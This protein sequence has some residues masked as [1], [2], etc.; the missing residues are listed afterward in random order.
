[1]NKNTAIGLLIAVIVLGGGYLLIKHN[2]TAD[3][4]TQTPVTSTTGGDQT[5]PPTP[6]GTISP[7]PGLPTV[8]TS[9]N[10]GP[11]SVGAIVTGQVNPNGASTTYWFDYGTTTALGT[12]TPAQG[13]GS[14][15]SPIAAPAY[16]TGLRATTQYY[17]RLSAQN[18]FGT[19]NGATYTLMTNN[20]PPPQG[21]APTT[22]T[23]AA[24]NISRTTANLNGQVKPNNSSTTYWFEYGRDSG[25]GSVTSPQSAGSGTAFV[26]ASVSVSNLQPLTQYFF[27]LNAQNQYGTINGAILSFTT[28]GPSS[29]GTPTVE[30]SSPSNVSRTDAFLNGS[31]NPNG[32]ATTYWFEY[33]E[34]SLL[35][36]LI[37]SG[38]PEKTIAAG[39]TNVKVQAK[40]TG[41]QNNTTYYYHLVGRNADGT[42]FGNVVS[43]RTKS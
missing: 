1:M 31:I 22:T 10:T 3:D 34:D 2:Q 39:T 25:L 23:T 12:Q 7:T 5:P 13:V 17:F 8:S 26:S 40:I 38:T 33:S 24:S 27:R 30:T 35:G 9:S 14:G 16:I 41:L 36:T 6:V 4:T 37:G 43:F 15:Y 19:V 21:S 42:V 29:T 11:S 32:L 28:K 20:N 18:R